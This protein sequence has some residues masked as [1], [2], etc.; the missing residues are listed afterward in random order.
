[1]PKGEAGQGRD[2]TSDQ[3]TEFLLH[4]LAQLKTRWAT[5]TV[6][7]FPG[8]EHSGL[9]GKLDSFCRFYYMLEISLSMELDAG[10]Q[11]CRAIN[12]YKG[13]SR[14]PAGPAMGTALLWGR[15]SNSPQVGGAS[16]AE[17]KGAPA[18][19]AHTDHPPRPHQ[20]VPGPSDTQSTS[21]ASSRPHLHSVPPS[22]PHEGK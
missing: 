3:K 6:C 9:T 7:S 4:V 19:P 8:R 13:R 15:G 2:G 18:P 14:P 20:G 1:M 11:G 12:A 17:A 21:W 10:M 22:L 5:T 16:P